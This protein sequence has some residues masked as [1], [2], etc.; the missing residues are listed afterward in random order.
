VFGGANFSEAYSGPTGR[1][2]ADIAGDDDDDGDDDIDC[3]GTSDGIIDDDDYDS[4]DDDYDG[5][6]DD[7]DAN[8]SNKMMIM[9]ID[10]CMYA[11]LLI[12]V[13]EIFSSRQAHLSDSIEW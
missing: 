13:G 6:Y 12:G 1:T 3:S 10:I 9:A 11:A 7:D 4:D 5:D 2:V 8:N